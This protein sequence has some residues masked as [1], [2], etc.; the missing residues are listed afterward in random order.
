MHDL[1]NDISPAEILQKYLPEEIC[2]S[3]FLQN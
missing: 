3:T 2:M 1:E